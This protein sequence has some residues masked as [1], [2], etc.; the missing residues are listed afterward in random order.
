MLAPPHPASDHAQGATLRAVDWREME[1]P[2]AI[3]RWDALARQATEPNPF[4]ESWYL[5]PSLRALQ[6]PRVKV[7]CLERNGSL[8][9]LL[10]MESARSYYG[11]PIPHLAGW[12]H[13]NSFLGAP[14]VA[15]GAEEAF[16]TAMLDHADRHA[17]LGLF[18]HLADLPLNGALAD[19][20]R[21]VVADRPYGL[22]WREERAMLSS[23]LSPEAYLEASMSGKKR[24]ELRRQHA[25]LSETG[26]LTV[27]R[28]RDATDLSIWI[29]QFLTLEAAGWKGKA[30]SA[31][32]CRPDT[33]TL[34]RE[35]MTG[36]VQA[37]RLE[38]LALV[39]DGR[40]IAMLANLLTPP[41]GFSYKTAFDEGLSRFSPGVLLQR[42]NLALLDD[43][44]IEACD[45]CAS[46]DHP[47][48]DHIWRERRAVGRVSIG[49]GG[50]LRRRLF[51]EI[52]KRERQEEWK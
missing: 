44:A 17:G 7:W 36:A 15:R 39:L 34:F 13:P 46:A 27:E 52:V 1:H 5:L 8:I 51:R 9:G 35:A 38:R 11:R 22:V 42:E 18:L 30:G 47:M 2:E 41:M 10:P 40:P 16:W 3:A 21:A 25:R 6:P 48:I 19:A 31:L 45:S 20:L 28:H 49:I 12:T 26:A 50:A 24:K 4:L 33:A 29:E 23:A 32:A 37:G 14:L 43:K